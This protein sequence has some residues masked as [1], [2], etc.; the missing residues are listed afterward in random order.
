MVSREASAGMMI[1]MIAKRFEFLEVNSS[2]LKK[3]GMSKQ[4]FRVYKTYCKLK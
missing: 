3:K 4:N 2:Q 1:L